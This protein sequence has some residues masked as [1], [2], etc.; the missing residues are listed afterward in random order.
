MLVALLALF[1]AL[2]GPAQ[3]RRIIDGGEIKRGTIRS[4]Q[5]KD[6]TIAMKD[7][8][9][10]VVRE[11]EVTPANSVTDRQLAANAVTTP[12]LAGASVTA[13][14][15]GSGAVLGSNVADGAI[16]TGKLAD[17]S[18]TGAKIADGTLTTADVARY[19]GRFRITV[20]PIG[21]HTCWDREP[22]SLAP[23]IAG[24]DISQ[25]AVLVTPLGAAF[26]EQ[27][28]TLTVRTSANPSRFV[29]AICNAT[30]STV[31]PPSDMSFS[32]V[33]FNVP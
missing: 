23:E 13:G 25:D 12:K 4:V 10:V 18:V 21:P 8:N 33:V 3:A 27:S 30:S 6:H 19:S 29:M 11:L 31:T 16:G 26:D 20:P 22:L 32:Y 28:L 14:K 1:I 9:P 2:G 7:L 5:I 24:A 15:L 17:G